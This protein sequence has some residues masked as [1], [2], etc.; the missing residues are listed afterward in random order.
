MSIS[1][2]ISGLSYG[3]HGM[4]IL[5]MPMLGNDCLSGGEHYNPQKTEHA[6]RHDRIRHVGDLGNIFADRSGVA[7]F[8]ITDPLISLLGG[9]SVINRT[10]VVSIFNNLAQN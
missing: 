2:R 8:A 1:G 4:H 3:L 6:D 10:L 5:E 9:F 7:T